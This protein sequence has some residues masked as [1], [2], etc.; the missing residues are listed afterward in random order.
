MWGAANRG[1]RWL[2]AGE[3]LRGGCSQDWLP[4]CV[5]K[6]CLRIDRKRR[7]AFDVEFGRPLLRRLA[8]PPRSRGRPVRRRRLAIGGR[9]R[10]SFPPLSGDL[11][12]V[13]LMGREGLTIA[14]DQPQLL[15]LLQRID[16]N[17]ALL[18]GSFVE[19]REVW[20]AGYLPKQI[21]MG[22]AGKN[23]SMSGAQRGNQNCHSQFWHIPGPSAHP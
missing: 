6:G 17:P 7:E 1:R 16:V 13:Q 4:H 18:P 14:A 19:L 20:L 21:L 22:Q 15:H 8:I 11:P 2:S 9:D 10:Q 12:K 23:S 3:P 5:F